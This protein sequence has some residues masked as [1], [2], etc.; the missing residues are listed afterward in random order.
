MGRIM[1][2][3]SAACFPNAQDSGLHLSASLVQGMKTG[4]VPV[5][6]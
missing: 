5:G 2:G 4:V 1:G 3:R 6:G